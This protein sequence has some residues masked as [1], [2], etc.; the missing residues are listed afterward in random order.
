MFWTV[1]GITA[2]T[3]TMFGF[4]P[5]G[6]KM[7][8]SRSAKDVSGL[9]LVQFSI[10]GI[11][12]LLYGIYLNDYIIIGAN[13]VSLCTLFFDLGIYMKLNQGRLF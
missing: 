8:K 3:L 1:I 11:L 4:L 7:F 9:T 12:W 10:G 2:A 6:I 5:Q 13:A